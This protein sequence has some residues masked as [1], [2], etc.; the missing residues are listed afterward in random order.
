MYILVYA[1][2]YVWIKENIFLRDMMDNQCANAIFYVWTK[3]NIFLRD[4]MDNQCA[5]IFS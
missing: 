2:F 3:E 1:I 4:M 5:N